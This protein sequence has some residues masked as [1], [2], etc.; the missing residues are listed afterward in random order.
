MTERRASIEVI[1]PS[2][3]EAIAKGLQDLGLGPE[4]VEVEVLDAGSKGVFGLGMRQARVRLTIKSEY[5]QSAAPLGEA[6]EMATPAELLAEVDEAGLAGESAEAQE[7][8]PS[9]F[10][11]L[12]DDLVLQVARETVE[13]LLERMKVRASVTAHFAEADE[14]QS[15]PPVLVEIH[16]QDLSFLIGPKAETLMALQYIANLIVTKE[17][18]RAITL[19]VDVEG[20]RHRRERQIRQ[21]ARRMAEQAMMTGRR[22]ELEP[23][24]ASE[25]R[26]VHIELRDHPHV[27][28]ESV[29]EEPQRKVTIIPR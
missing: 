8:A 13:D 5:M 7:A 11:G 9:H 22:Q 26:L 15:R 16:G 19:V 29:G 3:E 2:V 27:R 1:A 17:L 21:M 4:A 18:G 23:M 24:P 25:R 12:P 14:S 20:Y 6:P 10:P 28:T